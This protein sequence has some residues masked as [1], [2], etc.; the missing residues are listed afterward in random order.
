MNFIVHR[1]SSNSIQQNKTK[2]IARSDRHSKKKKKKEEEE[3][4]NKNK[5]GNNKVNKALV[6]V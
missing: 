6:I 4:G 2:Q 3:E 1:F 5:K